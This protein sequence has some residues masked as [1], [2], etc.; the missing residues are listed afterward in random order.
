MT[1]EEWIKANLPPVETLPAA[2][3][4]LDGTVV[5]RGKAYVDSETQRGVFWATDGANLSLPIL[6]ASLDVSGRTLAISDVSRCT[7]PFAA[8]WHFFL[9]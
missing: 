3:L 7:S 8:H 6:T 4:S 9:K 5:A 2:T 1:P